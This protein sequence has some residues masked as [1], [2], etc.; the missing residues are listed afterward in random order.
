MEV[1]A[2]FEQADTHPLDQA[3]PGDDCDASAILEK[4]AVLKI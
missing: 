2:K 1:H 3:A 4:T